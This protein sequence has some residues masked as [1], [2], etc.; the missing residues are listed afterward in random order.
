METVSRRKT[1]LVNNGV[2]IYEI[3]CETGLEFNFRSAVR[4][5]CRT[6]EEVEALD[7]DVSF[8]KTV[9]SPYQTPEVAPSTKPE[10]IIP[11]RKFSYT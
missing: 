6:K 1:I 10:N 5:P 8:K 4:K 9:R 7:W 2:H 11:K 3:D